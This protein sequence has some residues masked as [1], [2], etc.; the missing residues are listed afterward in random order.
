MKEIQNNSP[1]LQEPLS[2]IEEYILIL[3]SAASPEALYGLDI[4]NRLNGVCAQFGRNALGAGSLYPAFHRMEEAGLV[5][6]SWGDVSGGARRKY[7]QISEK[8][9]MSLKITRQFRASL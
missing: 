1:V 6:G 2:S 4:L 5:E 3:L 8:G 9:E 7:Y